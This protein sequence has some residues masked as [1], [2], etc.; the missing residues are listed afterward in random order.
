[1]LFS[2]FN[3]KP[4]KY[5]TE[6]AFTPKKETVFGSICFTIKINYHKT[7]VVSG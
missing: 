1:M 7:L 4:L 2:F 3:L 5:L 6:T